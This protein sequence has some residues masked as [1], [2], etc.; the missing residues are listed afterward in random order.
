MIQENTNRRLQWYYEMLWNQIY[1]SDEAWIC[2]TDN[3]GV[4]EEILKCP[5][6]ISL[7]TELGRML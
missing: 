7:V 6:L 2:G 1:I 4:L 5:L 3:F